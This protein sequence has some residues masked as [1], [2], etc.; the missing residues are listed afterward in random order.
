MILDKVKLYFILVLKTALASTHLGSPIVTTKN[1]T[2][3]YIQ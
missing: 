1:I 2:I 3:I